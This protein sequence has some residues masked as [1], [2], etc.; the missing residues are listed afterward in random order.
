MRSETSTHFI[1]LNVIS[2][3]FG[4][5]TVADSGMIRNNRIRRVWEVVSCC[6]V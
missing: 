1:S 5:C 4:N 2:V 3:R 6:P